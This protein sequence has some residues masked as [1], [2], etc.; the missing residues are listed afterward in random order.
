[1]VEPAHK[2]TTYLGICA[3][4]KEPF[5]SKYSTTKTCSWDCAD[6]RI[7]ERERLRKELGISPEQAARNEASQRAGWERYK[8]AVAARRAELGLDQPEAVVARSWVYDPPF[9]RVPQ[10][11]K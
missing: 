10:H 11:R 1:V 3:Q 7:K 9:R 2:P 6:A 5:E 4:C 8:A